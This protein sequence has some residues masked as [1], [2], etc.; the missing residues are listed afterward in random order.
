MESPWIT[1]LAAWIVLSGIDDLAVAAAW[2]WARA[3]NR[4][5]EAPSPA[6]L[7]LAEQKRIAIFVPCWQEAEVI[8]GMLRHNLSAIRYRDFHFFVGAYPNDEATRAAVESV[9]AVDARVHLALCPHDGPTSKADCLNWVYQ[10][11]RLAEEELGVRFELVMMHDAEDIIHPEEL[12][13]ANYFARDYGFVQTPVLPMPTPWR[14]WTHGF[15]IDDFTE[16][17]TKDL[18]ARWFLGGFVPSCG[19]G[20]AMRRDA[21]ERL[22]ESSQNRVFEPDCLTED[23]ELGY[24]MHRL[25]I[26][27]AFVPVLWTECDGA[28]QPVATREYFPSRFYA[29]LRQRTRWVTGIALQ[30]WSRHGWGRNWSERWWFWRDRKGLLGNPLS[31]VAN[32][33]F[34]S[35][36]A[37][38]RVGDAPDAFYWVTGAVGL[39]QAALRTWICA[40]VYGWAMAAWTAPR[41]LLGNLL[42]AASTVC[43]VHRFLKAKWEG[44]PLRWLK[45]EHAYPTLDALR[46]HKRPLGEILAGSGYLNEEDLKRALETQPAGTP[47]GRHLEKL[48]LITEESL[49]EALCLQQGIAGRRIEPG[50]VKPLVARSLPRR[51]IREFAV[52]P[53]SQEEGGLLLA[54]PDVPG[55]EL[56]RE[57]RKHLGLRLRFVL[58]TPRNFEQLCARLLA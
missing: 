9:A 37:G 24:K 44:A 5:P 33:L 49:L 10:R 29:A 39:S 17:H 34:V 48:G 13:W 41:M 51:L 56:Q 4:L 7:Q 31:V 11:M 54:S 26:R 2:L 23:Y 19:V 57:V 58:V 21:I 53:V 40:G 47:L 8:A 55:D 38:W 1:A 27:Q 42:N 50:E 25:G 28:R 22:A 18:P 35:A 52:L 15:Y 43:A 3:R 32:A 6:E 20:T 14:E 46:V 16:F 12:R 30:G 45:T 36:L